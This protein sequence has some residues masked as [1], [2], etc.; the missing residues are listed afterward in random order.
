ME[1]R[2]VIYDTRGA[3]EALARRLAAVSKRFAVRQ[4]ESA[5]SLHRLTAAGNFDLAILDATADRAR[6]LDLLVA[7]RRDKPGLAVILLVP[8]GDEELAAG[9]LEQGAQDCLVADESSDAEWARVIRHACVRAQY[10]H[11]LCA[12]LRRVTLLLADIPDYIYFKDEQGRFL[13]INESLARRFEL[14]SPAE[15]IG[16]TDAEFFHPA[17]AEAAEADQEAV[18]RTGVPILARTVREIMPDGSDRWSLTSQFPFRD[19]QGRIIGTYGISHDVTE[20]RRAAEVLR[21][22]EERYRRLL[23]SF[24]DYVYT[25]AVSDGRVVS[26]RH[27]PGCLGVTGYRAEQFQDDPLLWHRITHPE[28]RDRVV[29]TFE[30]LTRDGQPVTIEHR[31]L[32]ADGAV[33]W[34]QNRQVPQHDER[35]HII[36]YDG[37]ISDI[38]ERKEAEALLVRTNTRLASVLADLTKSHEQLQSTQMELIEAEKLQSI[39]QLA[40]GVAHEV[41]NPLAILQMGIQF[42]SSDPPQERAVALSVIDE[43]QKAVE[44]ATAV[45]NDLLYFSAARDLHLR[46][47][48]ISGVVEHALRLVRPSLAKSGIRLVSA[49]GAENHLCS[50]DPSKIEQALVHV[51]INACDAMPSG[52]TLTVTVYPKILGDEEVKARPG[53]R[54]GRHLRAG[55]KVVVIEIADTGAGISPA[56]ISRVFDPFYTTKG[57]GKG[58]GLGLSVSKRIIDLH[59]GELTISSDEGSGAKVTIL[60]HN[61]TSGPLS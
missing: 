40:A 53:D 54:T 36:A 14:H 18:V 61:G 10:E 56:S 34:V 30:R 55:D 1:I 2:I 24:T 43:M 35:G 16:R 5:E 20:V 58:R 4:V 41:K 9:A 29:E 60:L 15:A 44:R 25:V 48:A 13:E 46:E 57:T 37:L 22:S 59:R 47:T 38:T 52:G 12:Q 49:L 19:G 50:V 45:I 32:R 7:L 3:E 17:H 33:R 27:G 31:L 11:S 21:E 8:K 23:D 26:T 42:F 28:D 39:G 51:F 6:A